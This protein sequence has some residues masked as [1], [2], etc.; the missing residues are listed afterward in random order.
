VFEK[1]VLRRIFGPQREEVAGG[2]RRLHNEE[3]HNLYTLPNIIM[4]VKSRRLK[5]AVHV[6][7]MRKNRNAYNVLVGR[8]EGKRPLGRPRHRRKD[9]IRRRLREIGR[10]GLGWIHPAQ[11]INRW[12]AIANTV[13]NLRVP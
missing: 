12:R 3:L 5:L 1:R 13:M 2:W 7:R 10:E 11:N 9:N 8:P 4:V 6:E